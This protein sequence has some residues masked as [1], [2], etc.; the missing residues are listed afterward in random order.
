MLGGLITSFPMKI[1]RACEMGT[2]DSK[3]QRQKVSKAVLCLQSTVGS[4]HCAWTEVSRGSGAPIWSLP[5]AAW[6]MT[7]F[8]TFSFCVKEGPN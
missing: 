5:Q 8:K 2:A 3:R 6:F 4:T 7:V 1:N